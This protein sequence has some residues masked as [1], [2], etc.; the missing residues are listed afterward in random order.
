MLKPIEASHVLFLSSWLLLHEVLNFNWFWG[1]WVGI[2]AGVS[3]LKPSE[4][5]YQSSICRKQVKRYAD[6][7]QKIDSGAHLSGVFCN[8]LDL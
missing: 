6:S 2:L 3:I 1:N 5:S 4:T 8:A 7:Y